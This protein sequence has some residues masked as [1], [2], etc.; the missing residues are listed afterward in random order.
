[1]RLI[2]LSNNVMRL[3]RLSNNI[4]RLIRLSNNTM[5]FI[6]LSNNTMRFIRLSSNIIRL[7]T[8]REFKLLNHYK[9]AIILSIVLNSK[10][11]V[12]RVFINNI[13]IKY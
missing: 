12:Y 13:L 7:S 4:I 9:K 8:L 11:P 6:R 2:R 5:R 1:M 3:I 10:G